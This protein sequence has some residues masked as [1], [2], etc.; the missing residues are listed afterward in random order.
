MKCYTARYRLG[1]ARFFLDKIKEVYSKDDY[2]IE[3]YLDAFLSTCRSVIDYV[4][5]DYLNTVKPTIPEIVKRKINKNR[6]I[7]LEQNNIKNF[8]QEKKQEVLGFL[9]KHRAEFLKFRENHLVQYFLAKRTTSEHHEFSGFRQASFEQKD[10]ES[11]KI[12]SRNFI[13][14]YY[15]FMVFDGKNLPNQEIDSCELTDEEKKS[16]L[17]RLEGEEARDL[18]DEYLG[19]VEDFIEQFEK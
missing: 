16:L 17:I 7:I 13:P 15:L 10:G 8:E 19:L 1:Q 14:K 12:L 18:L 2:E 5:R 3:Y 6:I 11:K 4:L 9:K